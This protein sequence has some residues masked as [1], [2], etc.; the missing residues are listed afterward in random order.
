MCTID[1]RVKVNHG[2]DLIKPSMLHLRLAEEITPTKRADLLLVAALNPL[3]L[4]GWQV[5]LSRGRKI[6][7]LHTCI[8]AYI[9]AKP[10]CFVHAHCSE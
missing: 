10:P 5:R 9:R 2:R 8:H 3:A 7:N 1:G 4:L 6:P